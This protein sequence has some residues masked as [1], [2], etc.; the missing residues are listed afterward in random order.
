MSSIRVR[1]APSPTG[2]L[3]VGTARTALFNYLFAKHFGGTFVL[4]IEDTDLERSDKKYEKDI[5]DGLKWLGIEADESP[6][7]GGS[8]GPY[9]QSE[10]IKTYKKHIQ[11]LL[12]EGKA[13][14]CFHS[15]NELAEEKEKLLAAKRPPIHICEYRSL[16]PEEAR[17]LTETKSDFIIRFK[18]PS[19]RKIEFQDLIR[20]KVSFDSELLGDFSI[21]KRANVPLYNFAVVVDDEEMDISHVIRGEDHIS[22]TPKQLLLIEALGFR[23][24]QYAHIPMILGTD[25]SKLSKRHNATSVNE[26]REMGYL[27]ETLFNFLA[28]LGW[29]SG[30][31][32]ELFTKEELIKEFSLEKVQKSGAIFDIQKLDWMNGEYIRK[33]SL[34]ELV[35]LSKP[36]LNGNQETKFPKGNLVS[37]DYIKKIIALEQPRL[38]KL[39]EIGERTE[40]FFR[41]PQYEKDLLRWKNMSDEEITASLDKSINIL[42]NLE[43]HNVH[44]NARTRVKMNISKETLEETFLKEIGE[45]DKGRILWPLRA[46]LTGQKASPG[47]FEIME[48]LGIKKAMKRIK[49][50]KDKIK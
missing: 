23:T 47:P 14:Y 26:Y 1:I 44:L 48:I 39:S 5:F 43:S 33:K 3:H 12:T 35:E 37:N 20:E 2:P 4:R 29:N 25:R 8:H 27:P 10:R 45:G 15:E 17:I 7:R 19:G 22:N 42:S 34:P 6:E 31:D 28:L 18:T 38:K 36:F 21:A 16:D 32:K 24:P 13:F 11:T 50:A 49:T 30:T 46:A 9:R 40:Y 41:A